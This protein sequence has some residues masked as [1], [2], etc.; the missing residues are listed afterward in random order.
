MW[1]GSTGRRSSQATEACKHGTPWQQRVRLPCSRRGQS[2]ENSSAKL[3]RMIPQE[4]VRHNRPANTKD[5]RTVNCGVQRHLIELCRVVRDENTGLVETVVVKSG[6][7]SPD[8]RVP[9]LWRRCL[10]ACSQPRLHH[11]ISNLP[12]NVVGRHWANKSPEVAPSSTTSRLWV[13]EQ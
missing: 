5:S 9:S 8:K 13:P 1:Q 7:I 11:L 6:V 10:D 3:R 12:P 4:S 2:P